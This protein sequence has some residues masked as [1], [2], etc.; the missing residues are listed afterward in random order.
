MGCEAGGEVGIG[1]FEALEEAAHHFHRFIEGGAGA[2]L[3]YGEGE[4]VQSVCLFV[5]D[6]VCHAALGEVIV[7]KVADHEVDFL[8]KDG[9]KVVAGVFEAVPVALADPDGEGVAVD[10]EHVGDL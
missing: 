6:R 5:G 4:L 7:G 10:A 3:G 9:G 1:F 2:E 8:C